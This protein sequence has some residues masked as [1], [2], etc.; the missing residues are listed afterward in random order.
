LRIRGV[1]THTVRVPEAGDFTLRVPAETTVR[2]AE[3]YVVI[4]WEA[5]EADRRV[6]ASTGLVVQGIG[7]EATR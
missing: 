7:F 1:G 6:G 4:R 2:S 3:G 5:T